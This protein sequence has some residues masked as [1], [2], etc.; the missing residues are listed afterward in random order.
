MKLGVVGSGNNSIFHL[1]ALRDSGFKPEILLYAGNHK[2]AEERSKEFGIAQKTTN[3]QFFKESNIDAI[4]INSSSNALWEIYQAMWSLD[5]P[6]LIEKPITKNITKLDEVPNHIQDKTIVGLNRRLYSAVDNFCLNVNKSRTGSFHFLVPENSWNGS[7][8]EA[9][10]LENLY[11]NLIH[12]IDLVL[13]IFKFNFKSISHLNT[14]VRKDFSGEVFINFSSENFNGVY[15]VTFGSPANYELRFFSK[16]ETAILK[17]LE[18]FEHITHLTLREPTQDFPIR[19]YVPTKSKNWQI[20]DLDKE[21]KPGYYQQ[22]K[23][24]ASLVQGVRISDNLARIND[25]RNALGIIRMIHDAVL[26]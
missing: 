11:D 15:Q 4:L 22:A 26:S 20:S 9:E 12:T 1:K 23:A 8:G 25:V 18:N 6:I 13:Y 21:Y 16:G 19:S 24:L 3:I 7:W 14:N 2:R 5:I 10:F 17:P